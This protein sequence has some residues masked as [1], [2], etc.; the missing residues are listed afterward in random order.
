MQTLQKS[1]IISLNPS[2]NTV[3][4][5]KPGFQEIRMRVKSCAVEDLENQF[6]L[7]LKKIYTHEEHNG[8]FKIALMHKQGRK[9]FINFLQKKIKAMSSL[10]NFYERY[11]SDLE[12]IKKKPNTLFE[13]ERKKELSEKKHKNINIAIDL[14]SAFGASIGTIYLI[15][16]RKKSKTKALIAFA[17][18]ALESIFKPIA[19][20]RNSI[21]NFYINDLDKKIEDAKVDRDALLY[22]FKDLVEVNNN[23]Y[24]NNQLAQYIQDAKQYAKFKKFISP[25]NYGKTSPFQPDHISVIPEY[26]RKTYNIPQIDSKLLKIPD[27]ILTSHDIFSNIIVPSKWDDNLN[28]YEESGIKSDNEILYLAKSLK[29][30]SKIS[31]K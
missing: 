5:K 27:S 13:L 24:R 6:S 31:E 11:N 16:K 26:L 25:D 8:C 22:L 14:S 1:K 10:N 7:S 30:G 4:S 2:N 21:H 29:P 20:F 17:F 28:I 3:G 15:L 23:V 12:K 18:F 9:N 19:K